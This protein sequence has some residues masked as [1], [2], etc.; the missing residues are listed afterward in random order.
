M[1]GGGHSDEEA[2]VAAGPS[3]SAAL[4]E[5]T[6]AAARASVSRANL[7]LTNKTVRTDDVGA[8]AQGGS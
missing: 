5:Q 1:D 6:S 7:G 3:G 2:L 4:D 8:G